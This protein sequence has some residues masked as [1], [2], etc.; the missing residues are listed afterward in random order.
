VNT[1]AKHLR[2]GGS[3]APSGW[4]SS[5]IRD[6]SGESPQANRR[7]LIVAF[8]VAIAA[9]EITAMLIPSH[10]YVIQTQTPEVVTIAKLTRIEHRVKP[11]PKPTPKPIVHVK[12]I[13][14][15]HVQP[16]IVHPAAPS[17]NQHIRR[18]ASARP[19]VHTHYHSK[20]ATIHVPV[21][22]HGAGTSRTAKAPTG[23][24]GPGGTGT[25]ESG[26][27]QGT[28]GA[29]AANEPC[30]FVEF[31]PTGNP[32]IDRSTG[33]MWEY[34]AMTVH[35]PDGSQQ[36]VDLDYPWYYPSAEADPWSDY[37]EKNNPNAPTPFIFPPPDKAAAEPPLVQYVIKHTTA[38]GL[39]TLHDCPR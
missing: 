21:G 26:T 39:T 12:L 16:K 34:I 30:G 15:A 23:G 33:R 18:V 25:G 13:A 37:N 31:S 32:V 8:A 19:L 20:P 35:F 1:S 4:L 14:P 27:G 36:S 11:T 2:T 9:I 5:F 6:L 29:P 22:G 10:T 7:R 24:V 38:E 3:S 17:Q 28:G